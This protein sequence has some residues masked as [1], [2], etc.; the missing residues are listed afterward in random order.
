MMLL[1]CIGAAKVDAKS[2]V[3]TI[4]NGS[5]QYAFFTKYECEQQT[6]SALS[7]YKLTGAKKIS[8]TTTLH[9]GRSVNGKKVGSHN[10]IFQSGSMFDE[11]NWDKTI[12]TELTIKSV[13]NTAESSLNGRLFLNNGK[14][15]E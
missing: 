4:N 14:M 9:S 6:H 10:H 5:G 12:N 2:Y 13:N 15:A 1:C 11:W 3:V 8:I 7:A